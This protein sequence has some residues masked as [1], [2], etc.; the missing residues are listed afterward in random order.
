MEPW[1]LSLKA[2]ARNVRERSHSRD[3]TRTGEATW[4]R[5]IASLSHSFKLVNHLPGFRSLLKVP[6]KLAL[7][8]TQLDHAICG[9]DL[10]DG[11]TGAASNVEHA[12]AVARTLCVLFDVDIGQLGRGEDTTKRPR[13][14]ALG[15]H[16][17]MA[18][19]GVRF[20]HERQRKTREV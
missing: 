20:A 4:A 17:A 5:E 2:L 1:S 10:V 7:I 14:V 9:T 12:G 8:A 19:R 13:V 16:S 18:V 11:A 15:G 6:W 3:G